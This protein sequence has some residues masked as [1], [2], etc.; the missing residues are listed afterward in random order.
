MMA[1]DHFDEA[2]Y[3]RAANW[4]GTVIAVATVMIMLAAVLWL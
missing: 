3:D 4:L 2:Q 1:N